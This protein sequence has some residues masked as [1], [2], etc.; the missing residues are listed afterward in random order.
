MG[1]LT[2]KRVLFLATDGVEQIELTDPWD[3]VLIAG[4]APVLASLEMGSIQGVHHDEPG[5]RFHVDLAVSGGVSV[6]DYAGL[7]LPGGVMNPDA[8]RMDDDAVQVV[9]DFAA[10]GKPIA[11]ICHGPWLLV[12]AGIVEG[13]R[14]TSWPSLHTDIENAGGEW[15][16]EEVV[17]DRGLTT[18][19]K[20]ADLKAFCGKLVEELVEG[21]H[22]AMTDGV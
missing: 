17:V 9:K 3:A 2:G 12:E 22:A 11:A 18:S 14:L 15:V 13:R 6:D 19:R 20:P 21:T 16:D 7:V 5:D 8:L 1:T 10:A 4:G